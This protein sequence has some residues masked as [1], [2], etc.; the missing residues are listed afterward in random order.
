MPDSFEKRA[1][2]R[3]KLQKKREKEARKRDREANRGNEPE[4]V[5]PN[6]WIDGDDA[7]PPAEDGD[8]QSEGSGPDRAPTD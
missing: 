5:D 4:V 1:R 6:M 2:E 8:E 7:D 3:K